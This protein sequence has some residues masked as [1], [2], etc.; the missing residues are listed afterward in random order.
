MSR[1][2]LPAALVAGAML[3]AACANQGSPVAA[4]GGS[5]TAAAP[6]ATSSAVT[7]AGI[8]SAIQGASAVHIKGT[9]TSSGSTVTLDLQLNKNG[10]ASGTL[11]EGGADIP[12]VLANKVVYVQFT[13]DVMKANGV[14]PASAAGK[15]LLNKW[16]PS[17]SQVLSGSDI[18]S[19]VQPLLDYD[20]FTSGMISQIP[21]G[22]PKV[23]KT[24]T[25]NGTPV[26]LLT[27]SDGSTADVATTSPHYLMRLTPGPKDGSGSLDFT[28]WNQPVAVAAPPASEIY[29]GP[30]A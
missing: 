20:T 26:Q 22:D 7:V 16:V 18:V 13:G 14:Q 17:T 29:S 21:S 28:N 1:V 5:T 12:I 15:L 23:G 24:D 6:T 25:I 3:L 2:R 19:G 11:G 4:S 27:F 8:K 9:V 10:S 30:G